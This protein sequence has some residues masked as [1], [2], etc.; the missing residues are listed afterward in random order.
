MREWRFIMR[1]NKTSQPAQFYD[2]NIEKTIP[3]YKIF[4]EQCIDLVKAVRS[5]PELW[6][7]AGGGTGLLIEQASKIFPATSFVLSDPSD[8]MLTM[9]RGKFTENAGIKLEYVLG[10][11]E[12]LDFPN[13]RFDVITSVLSHHYFD[14]E[15][16]K[17]AT[18][19]CMRMLKK[20]GIYINIESIR[21]RTEKGRQIGITRW[22]TA[23]LKK[24][25]LEE[26]VCRHLGRYGIEFFPIKIED[27][28][29]MMQD[30]GFSTVELFWAS[31]LQAGFF[32]IK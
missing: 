23:Q 31:I 32:G 28:I 27:H 15:T 20:G 4:H 11:T 12:E 22:H 10:G 1:D 2:S 14:V 8:A 13:E 18:E 25:K 17:R 30:V 5:N 7:D 16:R 9:A 29:N 24:G 19:N 26:E 6:L 3:F 21:P